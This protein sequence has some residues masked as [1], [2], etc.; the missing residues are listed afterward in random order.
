MENHKMGIGPLLNEEGNLAEPGYAFGLVKSYDRSKIKAPKWRIKEWDYYYV[1]NKDYGVALTVADNGYMSLVSASILEFGDKP[2]Q[3]TMTSMGLFPMGKLKLPR[4]SRIG[5]V[6][7]EK[8]G[9]VFKFTHEGSRRRL[10]C[11][12]PDFGE[13][14]RFF[15]CDIYLEETN[16][17]SMVIATPFKKKG[18][19]YYN[20][21]I[22][23]QKAG[24][25]AKLGDKIYDFNKASYGVLDWGRGVW[26]YKNTWFWSSVN[27]E[28]NGHKIGWNLGY[29]FG[30]TKAASENMFF[31]DDK[32]YKLLDVKFDIPVDD[33]NK[34]SFLETWNF[35]SSTGDIKVKF[36]PVLD[37]ASDTNALLIRSNQ[38]QVFGYFTGAIIADDVEYYFEDIPGF[39]EKVFNKW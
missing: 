23:N 38:H 14:G 9:I 34:D 18:H 30:D 20:Q 11:N 39:A 21:K 6:V 24:G 13:K 31:F 32:A 8:K 36:R 15:H 28:Y 17:R 5:D 12:Y 4:D 19:F 29:G 7:Y 10:I 16:G 27:A 1:G 2:N 25:Y 22:N 35:R 26:T 33:K 3:I 37:R